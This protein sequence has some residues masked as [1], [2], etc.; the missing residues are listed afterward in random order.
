M[1]DDRD[2]EREVER[3]FQSERVIRADFRDDVIDALARLETKMDDV[4][5]SHHDHERRL[6]SVERWRWAHSLSAVAILTVL[7]KLGLPI[8]HGE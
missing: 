7:S 8:P 5:R 4:R 3:Q 2:R 6:R 1:G